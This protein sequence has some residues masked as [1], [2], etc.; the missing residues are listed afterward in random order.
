MSIFNLF[1]N[2]AAHS[3]GRLPENSEVDD[4]GASQ[5]TP[6]GSDRKSL[7]LTQREL[8]Y[9][10]I[11][12]VMIR[13]GVLAAS[14]RFK[15]L[16]LDAQGRQYLVMMD[17]LK[18]GIGELK[19]LAEIESL[20]TQ[21]AKVRHDLVVTGVYW[22]N[23]IPESVRIAAAAPGGADKSSTV[24]GPQRSNTKSVQPASKNKEVGKPRQAA[25]LP[26]S[27]KPP[28]DSTEFEDTRII[29]PNDSGSPLSA[30]QYGDLN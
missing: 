26:S 30:T 29:A 11:K 22:R 20:I 13:A 23:E 14:Y 27:R 21:A 28:A 16:S 18:E 17:L 9:S 4:E 19:S 3:S 15:V 25:S 12:D 5:P 7:R 2:K 24:Q 8:L 10:A 6:S 1:G